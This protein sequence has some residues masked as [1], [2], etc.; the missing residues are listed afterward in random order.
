[1]IRPPIVYNPEHQPVRNDGAA[2]RVAPASPGPLRAVDAAPAGG[3]EPPDEGTV[4]VAL[5]RG[6][7]T[8]LRVALRTFNGHPFVT[9]GPWAPG[10]DGRSW[11]PV[12]AKTTTVKVAELRAVAVGLMRAAND[13]LGAAP[14]PRPRAL[15][16]ENLPESGD[17]P[18]GGVT[19]GPR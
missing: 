6:D 16:V 18:S 8:E 2:L 19:R 17:P 7:G 4:L 14:S 13:V 10:R 1:M 5:P 15:V 9:V 12:R 11:W 3:G